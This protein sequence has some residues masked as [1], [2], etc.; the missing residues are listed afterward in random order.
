MSE[1]NPWIH[2][3][4]ASNQ[5]SVCYGRWRDVCVQIGL[6]G[7]HH[8]AP[9]P[10]SPQTPYAQSCS[11][12]ALMSDL[13]ARLLGLSLQPASGLGA[14]PAP[15]GGGIA[16]VQSPTLPV[17]GTGIAGTPGCEAT[18]TAGC[19][20]DVHFAGLPLCSGCYRKGHFSNECPLVGII[21]SQSCMIN[22]RCWG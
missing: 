8:N 2:V 16:V 6:L 19:L 15:A 7:F 4:R 17:G 11:S 5:V 22:I 18:G 9:L 10:T 12:A 20:I 3:T 1:G 21:F 13:E 14:A